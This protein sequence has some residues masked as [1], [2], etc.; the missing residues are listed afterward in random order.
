MIP[1]NTKY[2]QFEYLMLF[3][4]LCNALSTFQ[5]Y[6][7]DFFREFLNAFVIAYFNN[8]LIYN[9]DKKNTNNKF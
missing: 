3:F 4:E 7:N 1:F 2:K 8:I 6:V 5:N 9:N